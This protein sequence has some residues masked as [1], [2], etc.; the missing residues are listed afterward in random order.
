MKENDY[1]DNESDCDYNGYDYDNIKTN[2]DSSLKIR[3]T[4]NVVM[5]TTTKYMIMTTKL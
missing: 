2:R 3:V 4:R 1:D 5:K